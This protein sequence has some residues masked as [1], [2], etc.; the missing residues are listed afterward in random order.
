MPARPGQDSGQQGFLWGDYVDWLTANAGS[1]A[2]VADRLCAHRGYREDVGSVE[3]ALRRLR[4]RG[5]S[6]GGTWGARALALF[7]LPDDV[8][9]R[10]RRLGQYHSR[11]TDLPVS[12]GADLLRA[13]DAPPTTESRLGRAWL[14]L[15][16]ASLALRRRDHEAARLQLDRARADLAT[17]PPA[18]RIEALLVRGYVASRDAPATVDALLEEVPPLLAEV[19]DREDHACLTARLLDHRTYQL[20]KAGRFAEAEALFRTLPDDGPPFAQSRRDS[21][22]AYARWKQGAPDEA[23]RLAILAA[24]HAGDGGHVR[25]RAMALALLARITGDPALRARSV[26]IAQRLEDQT[27]L[28]RLGATT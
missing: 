5:Q 2:A 16:H 24:E 26:A 20:N 28:G 6:D 23:A 25:L 19:T 10:V 14:A 1:L 11:F 8:V 22:L 13:W 3:R 12:L 17:A 9:E 18:A 7:G 4:R 21:G 15:G 27:L